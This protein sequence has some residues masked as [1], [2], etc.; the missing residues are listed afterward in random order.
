MDDEFYQEDDLD[1]D[2][3]RFGSFGYRMHGPNGHRSPEFRGS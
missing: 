2:M 1:I 3:P